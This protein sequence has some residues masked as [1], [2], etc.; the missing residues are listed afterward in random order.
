M[1]SCTRTPETNNVRYLQGTSCQ[2]PTLLEL[3]TWEFELRVWAPLIK[4]AVE[5]DAVVMMELILKIN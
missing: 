1:F 3:P 4:L 2:C 5:T